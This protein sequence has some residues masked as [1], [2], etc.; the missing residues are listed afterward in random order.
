MEPLIL[1]L[2]GTKNS[3]VRVAVAVAAALL[4][5]NTPVVMQAEPMAAETAVNIAA[6]YSRA[7]H[8]EQPAQDLAAAVAVLLLMVQAFISLTVA[9]A[10]PA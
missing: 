2:Y 5:G 6:A 9:L 10:D 4:A 1:I 7:A 3:L 8:R